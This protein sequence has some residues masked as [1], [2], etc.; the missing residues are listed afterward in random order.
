MALTETIR[1]IHKDSKDVYGSP[2]VHAELAAVHVMAVSPKRV[3]AFMAAAD[4]VGVHRRK[5]RGL[6]KQTR[7]RHRRRT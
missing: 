1:K 6:T 2:R 3:A 7:R 5:S 4:V